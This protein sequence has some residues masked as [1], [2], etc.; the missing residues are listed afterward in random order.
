MSKFNK[1]RQKAPAIQNYAGG[2]AHQESTELELISILLTSFAGEQFYRGS[3]ETL[4][5]VSQLISQLKDK[6]FAAKA[7]VFARTQFGMRSITHAV[8]GEIAKQVKGEQWTRPF[9]EKVVYRADDITE[10]LAYY[11]NKYGK[12]LPNSL[13]D[14]LARA[15]NKFD[16]YQL[17]KYAGSGKELGMVDAFNLIH[18]KPSEKN[19]QVFKDLM[20]GKLKNVDT[21][22]A[23]LSEAGKAEGEEEVAELKGKAWKELLETKKLGI[24]ALLRNLRN[25]ITQAPEMVDEACR[26]LTNEVAIKKSLILPFRFMTAIKEIEKVYDADVKLSKKVLN[27]LSKALDIS[28]NNVPELEG[29]TLI[30]LDVSGSMS[31]KPSEIGS[32]FAAAIHKRNPDTSVVLTFDDSATIKRIDAGNSLK[33]IVDAIGFHGGGTNFNCIFDKITEKKLKFD[34]IIVL[35]DMQAWVTGGYRSNRP[36]ASFQNYKKS[37]GSDPYIYSFDLQGYGSLQFPE[38]KVFALAGFSEKIFD[39]M[40]LLEQ[41]KEALLNAVHQVEI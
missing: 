36:D 34:R 3:N 4:E 2:D 12:P 20:S 10:I 25:I 5:K 37:V 28:V 19:V 16:G 22:E 39:V 11:M 21:W 40:K 24:F 7:A 31:G 23:M 30:A 29:E 13:K 32:L 14:G 15:L 41:D 1:T 8:A 9:Y 33:S 38:N 26:Q 35:S 18:P 17:A 6:K 27:A